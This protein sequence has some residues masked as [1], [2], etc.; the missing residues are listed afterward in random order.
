MTRRLRI[1]GRGR[2]GRALTAALAGSDGWEVELVAGH[3]T[4]PSAAA[5]VDLVLLCVPDAA[6]ADVAGRLAPEASA[7]VA[8]CSGATGLDVLEPHERRASLHPL[9]SVPDEV[10]GA[11][12]LVGGWYAV[13][14][15]PL[16]AELV[17]ALRGRSV[18]VADGD[19]QR[20][21]AAAVVAS[22]HLVAL[23]GQV[24]RIAGSMGLPLDAFLDL[25]RGS[26]DNVAELGAGA[27]LT[28]PVARGDWATVRAHLAAI[29][30]SERAAYLAGVELA[31]RLAGHDDVPVE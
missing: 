10:R 28:G 26:L 8:H 25:A 29:D 17:E 6:I 11:A 16:V 20:Y 4:T 2:L 24:E 5:G 22:N 7:V 1:V 12:A 9:V 3:T 27:A 13:S 30:T 31:A 23:M 14:G 15:D 18:A 19:R 21:H